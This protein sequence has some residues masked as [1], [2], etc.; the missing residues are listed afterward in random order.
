MN[1]Y[2]TSFVLEALHTTRS[3]VKPLLYKAVG[4]WKPFQQIFVLDIVDW[5]VQML[6]ASDQWNIILELPIKDGDNVSDVCIL[7]SLCSA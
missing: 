3:V 2:T 7:Q 1:V 6:V 5:Y 4:L